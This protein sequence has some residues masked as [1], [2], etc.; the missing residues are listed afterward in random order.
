[1][2]ERA[3]AEVLIRQ[4]G[5]KGTVLFVTDPHG[6]RSVIAFTTDP[7]AIAAEYRKAGFQVSIFADMQ[8]AS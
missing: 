3:V 7:A 2:N 8:E 5:T 6:N 4:L 1:M